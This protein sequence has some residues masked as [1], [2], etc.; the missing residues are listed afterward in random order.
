MAAANAGEK[1]SAFQSV[2]E[3]APFYSQAAQMIH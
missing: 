2:C 3:T 1:G